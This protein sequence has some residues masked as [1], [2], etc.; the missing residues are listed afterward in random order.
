MQDLRKLGW[1]FSK[2]IQTT[3]FNK[4]ENFS[5]CRIGQVC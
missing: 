1:E 5:K 2:N 3:L 4:L